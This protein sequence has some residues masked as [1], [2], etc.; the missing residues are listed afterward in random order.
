MKRIQRG[1]IVDYQTYE[2]MRPEFRRRVMAEK[3][4]RRVHVGSHFTF[5]FENELTLRYQVQEMMRVER[6]VKELEILREIETYDGLLGGE[7]ELACTLL[8]EIDD[9][10]ERDARLREWHALPDHLYARMTDGT[11]VRPAVDE[12][13]RSAE[14]ISSVQYLKFSVG[15]EVPFAVG[16]DLPGM[17]AETVLTEDQRAALKGDLRC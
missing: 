9:P 3:S 8:V 1:D 15:S 16:V 14:R 10:K 17:S 12:G 6:I 4:R 5:L 13:Q 2:E 11:I 7:G